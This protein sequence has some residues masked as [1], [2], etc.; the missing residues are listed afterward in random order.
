MSKGGSDAACETSMASGSS[1]AG[2]MASQVVGMERSASIHET[3][4]CY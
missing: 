4:A 3:V 2:V 1:V